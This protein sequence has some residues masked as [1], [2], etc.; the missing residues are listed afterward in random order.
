MNTKSVKEKIE[1][2][3]SVTEIV[4]WLN[5][6]GINMVRQSPDF[7]SQEANLT[8]IL[9]DGGEIHLRVL[10]NEEYTNLLEKVIDGDLTY[11]ERSDSEKNLHELQREIKFES[12]RP[13]S[14]Y[15]KII[16]IELYH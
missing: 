8:Y 10:L 9:D 16:S 13:E 3:E 15:E 11:E 1:N 5:Q 4:E 2:T 12:R 6:N 7:I 14:H